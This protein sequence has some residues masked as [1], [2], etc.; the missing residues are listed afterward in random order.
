VWVL[1]IHYVDV[2]WIVMPA[3]QHGAPHP[4]WTDLTAVIGVGAA[5]VAFVAWRLGGQLTVPVKD[6]YLDESQ[7]NNP[8]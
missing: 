1:V 7:R 3:L 6:P 5:A 2:Y 8:S 4:H